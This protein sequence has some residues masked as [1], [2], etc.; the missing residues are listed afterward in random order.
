MSNS[1]LL[2][3]CIAYQGSQRNKGKGVEARRAVAPLEIL[4][5]YYIDLP[6]TFHYL[7]RRK[8]HSWVKIVSDHWGLSKIRQWPGFF[9]LEGATEHT[10]S[11]PLFL[12]YSGLETQTFLNKLLL[13]LFESQQGWSLSPR[14]KAQFGD[15]Y[16]LL[17]WYRVKWQI[18]ICITNYHYRSSQTL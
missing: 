12:Q 14:E 7:C 3:I 16:N 2:H 6:S 17:R 10:H 11:I 4:L 15:T 1:D 8:F 5:R 18:R 13:W 9:L